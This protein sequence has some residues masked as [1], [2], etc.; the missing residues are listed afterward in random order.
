M[1]L[2]EPYSKK[3]RLLQYSTTSKML[4]V[5]FA[6]SLLLANV[7]LL[8][9]TRSLSQ[10]FNNE[11]K[12]AT[13]FLFQLSKELSELVGEARRLDENV[14][15]IDGAELQYELAW[16]RFDL[17]TSSTK[18]NKFFSRNNMHLYFINLFE[19]FKELEKQLVEA[20]TG[21]S[22]A[23]AAFYRSTQTLYL[24]LID[25]VNQNFRLSSKAYEA[26]KGQT[27]RLMQ[28]QYMLFAT[29]VLSIIS[30]TY[31]FYRESHFHR[32]LALS[33]PLTN[34]GNRNALFITLNKFTQEKRPF[35][36]WILDLN[37]FKEVNDTHGHQVG[38]TV[39]REIARRLNSMALNDFTVY[40]MGGDEFAVILEGEHLNEE[41]VREQINT[42]FDAQILNS[43]KVSTLSTSMGLAQYPKDSDNVDFL[44]SIADKRMYK[45]KFQR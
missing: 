20:R 2:S 45:M 9:Q 7:V 22:Q 40:R 3:Q 15:N 11:Q 1:K 33:D 34:L 31:F 4:L 14:L 42:V 21:D 28:A 23:A 25:F 5:V 36:L 10:N 19:E 6:V 41:N 30:L 8:Q 27:Q 44:I 38:D 39:L 35:S 13:W 26:Q 18:A 32:K 37:G 17:L 16:S 43:D 29:F 24:G 12:Q